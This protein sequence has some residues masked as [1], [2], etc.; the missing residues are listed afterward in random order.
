MSIHE[1]KHA[2]AADACQPNGVRKAP[3]FRLVASLAGLTNGEA[4]RF[5][6]AG[7]VRVDEIQEHD[8]NRMIAE[9]ETVSIFRKPY[10]RQEFSIT[11]EMLWASLNGHGVS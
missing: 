6:R 4:R 3:L 7:N 5:V 1:E 10:G 11:S 8:E 2:A 9:G